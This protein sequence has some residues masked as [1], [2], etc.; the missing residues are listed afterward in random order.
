MGY[1]L[2]SNGYTFL[3]YDSSSFNDKKEREKI[4]VVPRIFA[5]LAWLSIGSFGLPVIGLLG[6][7]NEGKGFSLLALGIAIFFII[8]SL[9]TVVNVKEQIVSD[10]KAPKV[11][12]KDT[13]KLIF[14]NDQLVALIGT[15]L[16][17]NLVVQI[18]GGV[19][20]YYFK[21]VVGK[22]S[23]FSVFTG[24]SGVA[25]ITALMAFP[26]LS[27]K[28]GRQK[29]FFLACSLPIVGFGL[30]CLAG[31][32]APEN[33][34]LVAICGIVAKLGSGLSLGISTVMLADVVDYGEY[35]FGS[36]NE[37]VIFSVQTLLV[38]S[39]SAVGGWLIGVGLTLVGYVANVQQ[40]ASAIMGIRSLMIVFPMLLSAIGYIIYKKYYK[41]ND[42]YYDEIIEELAHTRKEVA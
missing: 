2:Y 1:D 7:G 8:A 20:I 11:N 39:A 19:A 21:Y 25:E 12:L 23:L 41:L 6:N 15:V 27:T 34:L 9:L 40:S 28:I 13:F 26:F 18:S 22:E 42:E 5:S 31:Y 14:K 36:R 30:L 29:V 10:Q 38:K 37:S 24:F 16:M 33:A 35:K 3:V 32:L 4:A 17:Y